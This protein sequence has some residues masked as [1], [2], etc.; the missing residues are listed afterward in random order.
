LSLDALENNRWDECAPK[1]TRDEKMFS[2]MDGGSI[3]VFFFASYHI[4]MMLLVCGCDPIV[5]HRKKNNQ[6][7]FQNSKC[8]KI[9][10]F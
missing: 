2:G 9:V 8:D 1:M 7:I 4:I 10:K 6:R 5:S 3:F